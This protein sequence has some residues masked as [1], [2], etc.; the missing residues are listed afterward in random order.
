[1][2]FAHQIDEAAHWLAEQTPFIKSKGGQMFLSIV[3]FGPLT[4]IPT[5][6]TAWMEPNIDALR[7]PTWPLMIIVN[8]AATL[9]VAHRGDWRM[10]LVSAI[11]IAMMLAVFIATVVR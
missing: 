6:W 3:L 11:W 8:L 10:R 5:V 1:M 2:R 7:T 4:F 9:S